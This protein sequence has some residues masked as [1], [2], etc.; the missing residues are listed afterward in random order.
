MRRVLLITFL[1]ALL[2]PLADAQGIRLGVGA[3]GGWNIPIAQ[4]DQSTGT[5][6]GA[7]ARIRFMSIFVAEPNVTFGKWGNPNPVRG[8]DLDI[9]GSKINSYGINAVIGNLPGVV[10]LKPFGFVG[11]SIY[12]ITNDDT[13]YDESKLGYSAGVGIAYGLAPMFDINARFTAAVAP[14]EK[15]TKKTGYVTGGLTYYFKVGN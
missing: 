14:Q 1:V 11:G 5:V 6:F 12:K 2:S 15:G 13:G 3:F 10:G 7:M 9:E 8:I 4:E